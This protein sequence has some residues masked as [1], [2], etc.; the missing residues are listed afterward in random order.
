MSWPTSDE[1]DDL[2]ARFRA[3]TL[4]K[5][6]WTHAAHLAV[7]TWHVHQLGRKQA[8]PVL[9]TEI[10]RLNAAHGTVNHDTGGY[11]E[12]I[13]GAYVHL[14]SDFVAARPALLVADCVQALLASPL[15]AKIALFR[16]YSKATLLSVSA[17][18]GWV[19]PDLAP[20]RY[21]EAEVVPGR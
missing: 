21:V 16:Y 8:L 10:T 17:R 7:G 4:P 18:K 1:L 15:A 6:E 19:E 2:V 11:H 12:T 20:L 13:T 14:V 5:H 9:R 3:G